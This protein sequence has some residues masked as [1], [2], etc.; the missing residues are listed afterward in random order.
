MLNSHG[1]GAQTQARTQRWRA[2]GIVLLAHLLFLGLLELDLQRATV[3]QA[4]LNEPA[5]VTPPMIVQL[6]HSWR[7]AT[8]PQG[9]RPVSRAADAGD[10]AR[11]RSPPISEPEPVEPLLAPR[12]AP[13]AAVEGSDRDA[14]GQGDSDARVTGLLRGSVGCEHARFAGLTSEEL[15]GCEDR[16]AG[17]GSDPHHASPLGLAPSAKTAFDLAALE[18]KT[19]HMPAFGCFARFGGGKF[20]WYH[21]SQGLKLGGLPC[22]FVAPKGVLQPDKQPA[23]GFM[24]HAHR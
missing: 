19:P 10:A 15:H 7:T 4:L 12:A 11:P 16:F 14:A 2:G 5:F 24:D 3:Q 23:A 8:K 17:P 22:Y 21:P 13:D 1:I 20:V 18:N 9:A 6:T